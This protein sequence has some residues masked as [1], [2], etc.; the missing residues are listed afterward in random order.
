MKRF[1]VVVGLSLLPLLA[2]GAGLPLS[3]Q[4]PRPDGLW[5][6]AIIFQPAQVELDLTVEIGGDPLVGTID[7]PALALKFHPLRH[8][9]AVHGKIAFDF[10][11]APEKPGAP[12]NRYHFTG[13]LTPDGKRITGEFTGRYHEMDLRL[14]FQLDRKG[15]A[16]DKRAD[17]VRAPLT[18]L[19]DTGDGLR[20]A[21]NRDH[22]KVRLILF[23]SPTC[24][25]CLGVARVVEKYVLDTIKDDNL[26]VYA[27]WGPMLGGETEENAREA[28]ARMPDSR[29]THFW[30]GGSAVAARFGKAIDLPQ[31]LLAWDTF[32]LFAP[33][34][35][36]GDA[37]PA[38]TRFM[39]LNKPLPD[40]LLLNGETLAAW[41]RGYLQP[42]K[43]AATGR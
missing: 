22:D 9:E 4:E 5:E 14:P 39:Q 24:P 27:V 19:A 30:T 17:E 37:V 28:T 6:G 15:N 18:E 3:A 41:I 11:S 21:F 31:G 13:E 34:L 7:L 12:E 8:V 33:G 35:T 2:A 26:R 10:D 43:A 40:A 16:G 32:Q 36:W 42:P 29:V 25:S 23:L 20:A 1:P 38:P